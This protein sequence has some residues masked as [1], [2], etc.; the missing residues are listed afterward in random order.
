MKQRIKL[1]LLSIF[2]LGSI[3]VSAQSG[4]HLKR[5]TPEAEGISSAAILSF[6]EAAEENIDA[7]HSFMILRHGKVVSEGWWAPYNPTSPHT[8]WSLSKSFT[9]TAIGFAVQENLLSLD[10]L[11]ISFFPDEIPEEPSWQ[12]K[13]LRIKD[14]LTMNT[15]HRQEPRIFR[16]SNDNFVKAFFEAE[17]EFMPGTHFLYNTAATYILSA[18]LQKVSGEKLVDFLEPRLFNPLNIKKPVWDECPMGINIGGFGLN[19]TTEDI[20]KLGQLYLQRGNWNGKQLLSE[21]WIEMATSKQVSNGSNPGND[22]AQGYGFQ[23]WRCRHNCYRGDGMRGQF[24]IIV[25]EHDAVIA[26][27]SGTDDMAGIMNLVWDILLPAMKK[28]KLPANEAGFLALK[29]KVANLSLKTIEGES[30]SADSKQINKKKYSVS[31]NTVGIKSIAFNLGKKEHSISIEM[32]DGI[33]VI[34]IGCGEYSK[35]ELNNQ[36][37]FTRSKSKKIA[38][39]G[40]WVKPNEYQIRIYQ[41]ETPEGLTYSFRFNENKLVWTT[42]GAR[43]KKEL[44]GEIK[45]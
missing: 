45:N 16:G 38:T 31:T 36:W 15:G 41:Y 18:I 22:W 35:S 27:T 8:M 23:F 2:I 30:Y 14:L 20:A 44:I 1:T 32:E 26:I 24:C 40:A 29:N 37:A 28:E 5:S 4:T 11:V 33:E 34:P 6:I 12:L 21:N 17:I 3:V 7:M 43:E 39:S 19:I 9:S 13:E 25:P 10:D 42:I